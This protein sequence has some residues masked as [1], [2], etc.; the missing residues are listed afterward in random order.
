[1]PYRWHQR[2]DHLHYRISSAVKI[3]LSLLY[4]INDDVDNNLLLINTVLYVGPTAL[5]KENSN[6]ARFCSLLACVYA[7]HA[8]IYFSPMWRPPVE[9]GFV[10]GRHSSAPPTALIAPR[11]SSLS[12]IVLSHVRRVLHVILLCMVPQ[13][14]HEARGKGFRD[15]VAARFHAP[16]HLGIN[17][18]ENFAVVLAV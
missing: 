6:G 12:L 11:P 14:G 4:Q 15:G 13:P 7:T 1:M 18:C 16:V 9:S 2:W 10:S 8:Y 5:P 17:L 3:L